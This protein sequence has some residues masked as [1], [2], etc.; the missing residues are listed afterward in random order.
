MALLVHELV[1]AFGSADKPPALAAAKVAVHEGGARAAA[2]T[3]MCPALVAALMAEIALVGMLH[4][5]ASGMMLGT[6]PHACIARQ[7]QP[8]GGVRRILTKWVARPSNA[9]VTSLAIG[10]GSCCP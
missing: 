6:Y 1:L 10:S 7:A 2:E 4:Q 3:V 9:S 8:C 5:T